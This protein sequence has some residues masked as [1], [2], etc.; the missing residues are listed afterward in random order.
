MVRSYWMFLGQTFHVHEPTCCTCSYF[1]AF[2]VVGRANNVGYI[3]KNTRERKK[4]MELHEQ[5]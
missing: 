5:W 1:E 3:A 4:S 2:M